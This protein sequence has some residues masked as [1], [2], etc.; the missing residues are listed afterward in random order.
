MIVYQGYVNYQRMQSYLHFVLLKR[1]M[2]QYTHNGNRN[3]KQTVLQ[4]CKQSLKEKKWRIFYPSLNWVKVNIGCNCFQILFGWTV[5]IEGRVRS[6][7][8]LFTII[9]EDVSWQLITANFVRLRPLTK[10]IRQN[11]TR[12]SMKINIPDAWERETLK[13]Q[14]ETEWQTWLRTTFLILIPGIVCDVTSQDLTHS[15]KFTC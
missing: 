2:V 5:A 7:W 14:N 6:V 3:S 11:S 10:N 1:D 9:P 12:S 4:C 15:M 8:N 13:A